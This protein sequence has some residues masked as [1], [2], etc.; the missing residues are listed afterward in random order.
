VWS[1]AAKRTELEL[2]LVGLDGPIEV[3]GLNPPG[4]CCSPRPAW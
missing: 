4:R 3:T 2:A 1:H